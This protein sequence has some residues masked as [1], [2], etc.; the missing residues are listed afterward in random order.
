M[1]YIRQNLAIIHQRIVAACKAAGRPQQEVKLL[2]ATK[3]VE[4]E[5]IRFAVEQGELLLGENKVQEGL[6]KQPALQDLRANWHF[7]GHLQSNKIKDVLKWANCIQSIDSL[8]LA[9]KL[10]E[11]LLTLDRQVEG[12][13]QVNTSYEESKSG[14]DPAE[15]MELIRLVK[16]LSHIRLTGL[17]TIGANT[18]EE[19]AVRRSFRLLKEIREQAFSEGII[20]P[21]LSMGMSQDLELAVQEG[22]TIV[23]VGSAVFGQRDY[24]ITA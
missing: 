6:A 23:R 5:K 4:P 20:L 19:A 10:N 3:T 24:S 8:A 9:Q 17:M 1:E 22:A 14:A 12:M 15:A 18:T 13:I 11:K 21:E 2:L 16:G 7:I